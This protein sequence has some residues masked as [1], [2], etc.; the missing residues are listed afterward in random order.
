MLIV[1]EV[2]AHVRVSGDDARYKSY[3]II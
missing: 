3:T 1:F 2:Q